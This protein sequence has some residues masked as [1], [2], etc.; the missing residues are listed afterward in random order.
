MPALRSCAS[1]CAGWA[2]VRPYV[3][4]D[5]DGSDEAFAAQVPTHPVF[6][7]AGPAP[8]RTASV[9]RREVGV[10]EPDPRQARAAQ[11]ELRGVHAGDE[12]PQRARARLRPVP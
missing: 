7:I 11:R 2:M 4:V 1:T 5:P 8:S 10:V 12:R 9:G 3:D 6:R